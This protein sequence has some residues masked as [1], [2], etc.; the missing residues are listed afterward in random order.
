MSYNFNV[1]LHPCGDDPQKGRVQI[2]TESRY[3]Y[4]ERSD[5]TEGGGLWFGT[6]MG[7]LELLDYDGAYELP[8]AVVKALRDYGVFVGDVFD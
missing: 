3:G 7:C 8:K 1:T 5:G 4:W 2:D 6:D